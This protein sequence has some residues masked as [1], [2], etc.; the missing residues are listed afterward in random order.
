MGISAFFS[1]KLENDIR[2]LASGDINALH[3]IYDT[4]KNSVFVFALRKLG[5]H[6]AAE[7]A[8]Q[9]TYLRVAKC[10]PTYKAG[11]NAR[12]WILGICRNICRDMWKIP[13]HSDIDESE[14]EIRE[15]DFSDSVIENEDV[16]RA[17][18]KLGTDE[19]EIIMLHIYS[20]MKLTDIAEYLGESY[21]SVRSKYTYSIKKLKS[22]LG[23]FYMRG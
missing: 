23:K 19:R 20:E 4:T 11:T 8:M 14:S 13:A 6:A 18:K 15:D 9:E 22:D 17:L 2:S 5:N 16:R 12:A 3:D 10:A 7:D 21:N 1:S